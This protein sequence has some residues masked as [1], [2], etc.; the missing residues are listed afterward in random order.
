MINGAN[1]AQHG[2]KHLNST[3]ERSMNL[4]IIEDKGVTNPFG[5]N[6]GLF[7]SVMLA[8]LFILTVPY[9]AQTFWFYVNCVTLIIFG[10]SITY[11]QKSMQGLIVAK[12]IGDHIIYT[13]T[14]IIEDLAKQIKELKDGN[15]SK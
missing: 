14:G 10:L 6:G 11:M 4:K 5:V 15:K 2:S 9:E 3:G 8:G 1:A 7:L 12:N 13:L